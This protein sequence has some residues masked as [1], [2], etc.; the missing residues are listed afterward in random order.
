MGRIKTTL[1]KRA[2][3]KLITLYGDKFKTD[4]ESNKKIVDEFAE[5]KSKKLRNSIAGY[6]T[7][8][9]KKI[10]EQAQFFR[11]IYK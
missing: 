4:F 9:M 10:K 2:T 11:K 1:V 6:I 8:L 3:K 5:I 7:R